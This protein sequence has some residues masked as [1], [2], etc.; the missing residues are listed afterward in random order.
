MHP[1]TSPQ[2]LLT[3]HAVLSLC[4]FFSC[5]FF[6]CCSPVPPQIEISDSLAAELEA[7]AAGT[8]VDPR[9]IDAIVRDL[10]TSDED[11]EEAEVPIFARRNPVV[12]AAA[13]SGAQRQQ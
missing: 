12:A 7:L 11:L 8:A 4:F 5:F 13:V 6:C 9:D 3:C 2:R 1:H 10:L